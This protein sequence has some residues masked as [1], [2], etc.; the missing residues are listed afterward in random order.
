MGDIRKC[1][2]THFD[3][4]KIVNNVENALKFINR[5]K[6]FPREVRIF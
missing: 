2:A 6:R 5:F 4:D 3:I 1:N